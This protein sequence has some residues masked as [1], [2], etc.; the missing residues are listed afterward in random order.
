MRIVATFSLLL[1][2]SQARGEFAFDLRETVS[3]HPSL[4]LKTTEITSHMF[5]SGGK[6]AKLENQIV[7]IMDHDSSLLTLVDYRDKKFATLNL[8]EATRDRDLGFDQQFGQDIRIELVQAGQTTEWDGRPVKRDVFR[9]QIN[10]APGPGE[11]LY[12][13]DSS[14]A[15][16]PDFEQ[17]SRAIA[18]T[19]DRYDQ[20]L[21]AEIQTLVFMNID[22]FKDLQKARKGDHEKSSLVIHTIAEFRLKKGAPLL[23]SIGPELAGK[24]LITREMEVT[25]FSLSS[26]DQSVFLVPPGFERVDMHELYVQQDLRENQ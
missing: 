15:P 14:T 5:I 24:P 12:T 25:D 9:I 19:D 16:P 20:D 11:W 18:S 2:A 21:D 23:D 4:V 8:T 1:C 6:I 26:V 3:G 7:Q 22:R 17:T 13:V 10:S